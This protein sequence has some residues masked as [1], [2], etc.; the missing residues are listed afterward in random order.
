MSIYDWSATLKTHR[1]CVGDTSRINSY[2]AAISA[3][4]KPG[5]VVVDVGTGTGILAIMA[6]RAGAK[7]V[8]AIEPDQI[9]ESA[10]QICAANGLAEQII[11]L[12]GLSYDAAL[13]EKADVLIAGH[14]HN[15]GLEMG[16]LGS[17][18]DAQKRF[19]KSGASIIPQSVDLYVAPVELS[20][21]YDEVIEFWK[22]T[23]AGVDYSSVRELAV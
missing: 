8:Y 11:F 19:L 6:C 23:P 22:G 17:V 13:P 21:T 9:I 16:L 3:V 5:D 20:D 18:I 15:F 7:T 12:T 10:R 1:H 14:L 4:V 2:A